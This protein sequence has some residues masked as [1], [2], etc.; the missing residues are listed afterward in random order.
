MC[1]NSKACSCGDCNECR[2]HDAWSLFDKAR[3]EFITHAPSCPECHEAF[4]IDQPR[5]ARHVPAPPLAR[6]GGEH[7]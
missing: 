7:P 2:E 4:T 1:T 5:Q 6:D 3:G